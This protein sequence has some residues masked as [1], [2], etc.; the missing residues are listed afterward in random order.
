MPSWQGVPRGAAGTNGLDGATGPTGATGTTGPTGAA[1]D[2]G[3]STGA[4]LYLNYISDTIPSLVP[5]TAAQLATITGQA[6][7]APYAISY[8]PTQN[9]DVSLLSI[10]PDLTASQTIITT[11]VN[12]NT[13][14]ETPVVQFGVSIANIPGA[15][16]SI[17]PGIWDLNLYAKADAGGDVD[18]IGYRFYLIGIT[19][20]GVYTNLVA[21][22]SEDENVMSH[23]SIQQLVMT[24]PIQN[25]IDISGY[26]SLMVAVT[27]VN[28]TASRHKT[29]SYYQSAFTYSHIH[30]SFA[31]Q[32]NTGPTGPTGRTG[33]TGPTGPTGWTGPT[34]FT[35]P[36]GWT[37]PTGYTGMTGATGPAADA[38]TWSTYPATQ[39]VNINCFELDNVLAI[40]NCPSNNLNINCTQ[41][42]LI[43]NQRDCYI[44][45][46]RGANVG[47]TTNI[48]LNASNGNKGIITL[49][50]GA[51]YAGVGGN[52]NLLAR[53][54]SS[55]VGGISYSVGGVINLTATT[56]VATSNT[57]TSAIKLNAASVVNYAGALTPI[58]SLAGYNYI[59]ADN[60]VQ[61]ISG[62]IPTLPSIPGTNYLY[63][64]NGTRIQNGIFTD[65]IRNIS[66]FGNLELSTIAYPSFVNV[67]NIGNLYGMVEPIT[68]NGLGIINNMSNI[69]SSNY[70]GGSFVG[71]TVD[72]TIGS[73]SSNVKTQTLCNYSGSNLLITTSNT[74]NSV[75]MSNAS[76]ITGNKRETANINNIENFNL[77]NP[78]YPQGYFYGQPDWNGI[79][80][81][82]NFGEVGITSVGA[83]TGMPS[84]SQSG[85][86]LYFPG[87][88]NNNVPGNSAIFRFSNASVFQN[89]DVGDYFRIQA[90]WGTLSNADTRNTSTLGILYSSNGTTETEVYWSDSS[91]LSNEIP[92]TNIPGLGDDEWLFTS[93][94]YIRFTSEP[95]PGTSNQLNPIF[96]S[97]IQIY[98]SSNSTVGLNISNCGLI[99]GASNLPLIIG[100]STESVNIVN[101]STDTQEIPSIAS[102]VIT[103]SAVATDILATNI[104]QKRITAV[105]YAFYG[106]AYNGYVSR[107]Y[108]GNLCNA[109]YGSFSKSEW[110][111]VICPEV[112][113]MG[114]GAASSA[115]AMQI[116]QHEFYAAN[117]SNYE[118]E[119]R[120][121]SSVSLTDETPLFTGKVLFFPLNWIDYLS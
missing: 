117:T 37:G 39:D 89:L 66:G 86:A 82:A 4:V 51:G 73:F 27:C 24:M 77:P 63:G 60:S 35:G 13:T 116:W 29:Q 107:G 75:S 118:I 64:T 32:G 84:G 25:P 85:Y 28:R 36:T 14:S 76:N 54:G 106:G 59:Q 68:S 90:W 69:T 115:A 7:N 15:P 18:N 50:A 93:N 97:Q 42:T 3:V 99:D 5:R 48:E 111:A 38:S 62:T 74:S 55:N 65:T 2:N 21:G 81:V 40:N 52:I 91:Y 67:S 34:G 112:T 8:A 46:D 87:R 79:E 110:G 6:M 95:E 104:G 108:S 56:V 92:F 47:L 114:V 109:S 61:M 94:G 83:S 43:N 9:A 105:S 31:I 53:G 30:S 12:N 100:A 41:T 103:S 78:P 45:A 72:G 96:W 19:S 121:Q 119:G 11:E 1:G 33:P 71:T 101:W 70:Q 20:G 22:G 10:S 120:V 16:T 113:D 88:A 17:P 44:Y 23:L 49:D 57:L 102:G 58:G 80:W 98:N 26:V